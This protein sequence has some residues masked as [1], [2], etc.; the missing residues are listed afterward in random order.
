MT[1]GRKCKY[2]TRPQSTKERT[3]LLSVSRTG[4]VAKSTAALCLYSCL[5]RKERRVFERKR[6]WPQKL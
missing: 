2:T 5:K 4:I 1:L 6:R 3:A